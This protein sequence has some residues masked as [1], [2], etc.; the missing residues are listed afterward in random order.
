MANETSFYR[1]EKP[2]VVAL[3]R[4]STI[5]DLRKEIEKIT[6]LSTE[7]Y[8]LD[9][10]HS[11][12]GLADSAVVF[13]QGADRLNERLPTFFLRYNPAEEKRVG[14]WIYV[15]TLTGK[16]LDINCEL[17]DTID[18]VKCMIQDKEGIPPDQQRL[19]FAG[20]GKQLENGMANLQKLLYSSF[21]T[22]PDRTLSDYNVQ[23]V[24]T[25]TSWS[26]STVLLRNGL[27]GIDSP[28]GSS[29]S[30]RWQFG[31]SQ[32]PGSDGSGLSTGK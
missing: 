8:F 9:S 15:K 11:I 4:D 17:S 6:G 29:P 14:M 1:D 26:K 3:S 18:N 7:Q 16:V 30:R 22:L 19:I 28:L 21:L 2:L 23:K 10:L 32:V 12:R 31:E 24:S 27:L 13:G 5:L 25:I 20:V